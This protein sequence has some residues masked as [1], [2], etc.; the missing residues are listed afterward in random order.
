MN[1]IKSMKRFNQIQM[2]L[3]K[4]LLP[5]YHIEA[6]GFQSKRITKISNYLPNLGNCVFDIDS[7]VRKRNQTTKKENKFISY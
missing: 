5:N 3:N 4:E 2:K 6:G 1:L 7:R